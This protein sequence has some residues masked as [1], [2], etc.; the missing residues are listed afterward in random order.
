VRRLLLAAFAAFTAACAPATGAEAPVSG[1]GFEKQS[2]KVV[3]RDG[4]ARRTALYLWYPSTAPAGRYDYGGQ[5]GLATPD[6]PVAPGAH[7]L[8][9]FSHGYLGG[10]DQSI[11]LCEALA[12]AGYVVAALD[13]VD[14]VSSG[15]RVAIPPFLD[16]AGWNDASHRDR[17]EDLRFLLDHLLERAGREADRLHGHIQREAIGGVGHSLGG[18]TLL[19]LVGG[20]P[21]WREK[22]LRAVALLSPYAAPFLAREA[23]EVD[24]PVMLQ[25]GT[26]DIGITPGLPRLYER[27]RPPKY[28]LVLAAENHFGWTNFACLGRTTLDCAARGNPAQIARFTL[29]FLDRHL[30]G[31]AAPILDAGERALDS[32]QSQAK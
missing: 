20:W 5:I 25:G 4:A 32:Y 28:L 16:P 30:R 29:A 14:A 23:L 2:V 6:A 26:F 3:H 13:H 12:R 21:S 24:V 31:R 19:G 22:R 18:Y 10:G 27:L 1:V 9:L 15:Q 8:L 17:A 7:P 11:F